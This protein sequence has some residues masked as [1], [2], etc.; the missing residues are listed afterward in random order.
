MKFQTQVSSLPFSIRSTHV[1]TTLTKQIQLG[2]G[3]EG[4]YDNLFV[5]CR[6]ITD[7]VIS[8]QTRINLIAAFPWH[9]LIYQGGMTNLDLYLE[10]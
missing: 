10:P 4:R 3:Y 7:G 5:Y 8:A 2:R 9:V 1:H 6:P